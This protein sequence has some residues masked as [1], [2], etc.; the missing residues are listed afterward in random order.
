MDTLVRW[1]WKLSLGP[2]AVTPNQTL[3]DFFAPPQ[4]QSKSLL[5]FAPTF[6][7]CISLG[8]GPFYKL[9]YLIL[10]QDFLLATAKRLAAL[11]PQRL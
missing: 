10:N 5:F 2:M 4:I 3:L 1:N 8:G 11:E 7:G 6:M 9:E